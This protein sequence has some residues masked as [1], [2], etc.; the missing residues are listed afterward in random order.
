MSR[1][2][3]SAGIVVSWLM[4]HVLVSFPYPWELG[5]AAEHW[6]RLS[7][8][9]VLWM[10]VGLIA[11]LKFGY[12]GWIGCLVTGAL[13]LVPLYGLAWSIVPA[14]W[15]KELDLYNDIL[16][17][18]GLIHVVTQDKSSLLLW[19]QGGAALLL[20]VL[21]ILVT[22]RAVRTALRGAS[23]RAVYGILLVAQGAV[24]F[25]W[26]SGDPD[27]DGDHGL[28]G[29]GMYEEAM[30]EV[31]E[32]VR[33]G[34]WRYRELWNERTYAAITKV[35]A[36]PANVKGLSGADVHLLF[37][38]SYGRA[39]FDGRETPDWMDGVRAELEGS[40][41]TIASGF[42]RP[43]IVGG[44][45]SLAHGELLSGIRIENKRVWDLMLQGWCKP[46]PKFFKD[47]GYRTVTVHPMMNRSWPEGA[48]YYG[49]DEEFFQEALGYQGY[50]YHWGNM[51]DQFALARVLD[52]VVEPAREPLF[53]QFVSVTS[54]APF[55][56]VPPYLTDWKAAADT[57]SWAR[58]PAQTFDIHWLNYRGHVE[59]RAAYDASIGCALRAGVGYARRLTRPSL[60]IVVGDHQPPG[61]E[62]WTGRSG[63]LGDVPIHFMAN[64]PELLLPLESWDLEL[65]LVPDPSSP[66]LPFFDFLSRFLDAYGKRG[67]D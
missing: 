42:A 62:R 25:S 66:A 35:G 10:S 49:F 65:G 61:F 11:V 1:F 28:L 57:A 19:A 58:E 7:P 37:I 17:I 60:V 15:G 9:L 38:E 23:R 12:R 41:L 48:R 21:L 5:S 40:G 18:P 36:T 39:A 53:L 8:D 29:R 14:F 22:H 33:S 56:E 44:M 27:R 52:V 51:P 55:S 46:L 63:P 32:I 20:L 13:V 26:M 2:P 34:L 30:S 67:G 64:R 6:L 4:L 24:L 45:S 59:L 50:R 16:M 31:G 3:S 54:H 43:S 47:A